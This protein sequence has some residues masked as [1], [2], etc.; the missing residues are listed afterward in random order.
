MRHLVVIAKDPADVDAWRRRHRIPK[1]GV[2]VVTDPEQ[3]TGMQATNPFMVQLPGG[4][5]EAMAAAFA[6][7]P[8]T[9]ARV[10]PENRGVLWAFAAKSRLQRMAVRVGVR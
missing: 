1:A 7:W 8:H 4:G 9:A 2:R 6:R 10:D 5:D 3:V